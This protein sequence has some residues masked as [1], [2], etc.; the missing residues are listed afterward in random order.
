[1]SNYNIFNSN[2]NTRPSNKM[3]AITTTTMAAA[4]IILILAA[5]VPAAQCQNTGS[6][7]LTGVAA[8]SY[9]FAIPNLNATFNIAV[10]TVCYNTSCNYYL[11]DANNYAIKQLNDSTKTWKALESRLNVAVNIAVEFSLDSFT[12]IKNFE[13]QYKGTFLLTQH[14]TCNTRIIRQLIKHYLT[15]ISFLLFFFFIRNLFHC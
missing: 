7:S 9:S 12:K 11:V 4:V 3:M 13:K 10:S 8:P 1:M 14:I 2:S 6:F 15:I 5:L